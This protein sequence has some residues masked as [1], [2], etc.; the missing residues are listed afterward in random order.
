MNQIQKKDGMVEEIKNSLISFFSLYLKSLL[1]YHI[2]LIFYNTLRT[3]PM[4]YR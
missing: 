4:L 1:R 2:Q 3:K